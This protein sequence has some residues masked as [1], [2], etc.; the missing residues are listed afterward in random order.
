MCWTESLLIA[1]VG[2]VSG[3]FAAGEPVSAWL[4][5]E[6]DR[7]RGGDDSERE[8]CEGEEESAARRPRE[9]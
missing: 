1:S 4:T 9:P 3:G 5:G 6:W 7:D 2:F 8:D